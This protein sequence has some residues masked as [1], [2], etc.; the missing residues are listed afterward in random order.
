MFANHVQT[1]R[2]KDLPKTAGRF[3]FGYGHT[4]FDQSRPDRRFGGDFWQGAALL[5]PVDS[6]VV[7]CDMDLMRRSGTK[8]KIA[9]SPGLAKTHPPDRQGSTDSGGGHKAERLG[10]FFQCEPFSDQGP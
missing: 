6:R 2:E 5:S 10:K 4:V 7:R 3:G 1:H 9:E 8:H